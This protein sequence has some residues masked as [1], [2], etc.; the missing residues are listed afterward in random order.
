LGGVIHNLDKKTIMV[1]NVSRTKDVILSS[2]VIL[3]AAVVYA[4]A[5]MRVIL[6]DML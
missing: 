5:A 6:E 4:V 2:K 1:Y 3:I